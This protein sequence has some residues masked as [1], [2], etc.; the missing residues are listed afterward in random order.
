MIG[1]RE[2]DQPANYEIRIK[3]TLDARWSSWF[4]NMQ[5]IPQPSGECLLTGPI[6]DQAALYGAISR[7]RDLG[8][9]LISIHRVS[10]QGEQRHSE[11]STP[12]RVDMEE[13]EWQGKV[14]S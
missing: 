4:A 12:N 3:G 2:Y 9:V 14:F 10:L 13:F 11:Y 6:R 7:L 8:L 5:I 1:G